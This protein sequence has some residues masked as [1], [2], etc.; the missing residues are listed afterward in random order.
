MLLN[1]III[2]CKLYIFLL[3]NI[4]VYIFIFFYI[5]KKL[6]NFFYVLGVII[7][8][9]DFVNYFVVDVNFWNFLVYVGIYRIFIF[10]ENVVC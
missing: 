2:K 8:L 3:F 4:C 5:E 6:D 9:K 7:I 1:L 10:L